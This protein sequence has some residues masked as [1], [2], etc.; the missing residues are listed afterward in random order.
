MVFDV[1]LGDIVQLR[2]KHP[3]GHDEW[4]V[5]RLGLDIGLICEGCDRRIL[6]ARSMFNKRCK[7]IVRHASD[8]R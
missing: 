8:A 4:R 3:C 6:L 7:R 5:V 1:Q 2:K